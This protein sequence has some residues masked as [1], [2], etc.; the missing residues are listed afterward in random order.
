M[1]KGEYTAMKQF[2]IS[3][4]NEEEAALSFRELKKQILPGSESRMLF[5][6]FSESMDKE[7][8]DRIAGGLEKEFPGVSYVGCSTF[9]NIIRGDLCPDKY[10]AVC[11][12]FESPSAR[13]ETRQYHMGKE[14]VDSVIREVSQFANENLWV[15]AILLYTTVWET[16]MSSLCSELDKVRRDVRIAGGGAINP[17]L[18]SATSFVLSNGERA[19]DHSIVFAFIGGDDLVV[20]TRYI[21]GWKPLGKEM[22]ITKADGNILQEIE[23]ASAFDTYRRYLR[24]ENDENFLFNTLEFPY[25]IDSHGIEILRHPQQCLKDGSL[26]MASD[27]ERAGKIRLAYGDP[28]TIMESVFQN[29]Q[30]IRREQPD[31]IMIFSCAGR[32]AFWGDSDIGNETVAFQKIA[33]SSGFYTLSEF[34]RTGEHVNQHNLTLVIASMKEILPGREEEKNAEHSEDENASR[35]YSTV[36]RLANFIEEATR[37]LE[38]ANEQLFDMNLKLSNMAITDGMTHLY[39]RTEIQRRITESTEMDPSGVLSLIML[40]IDDFKKINDTFGHKE[41]DQVICALSDLMKKYVSGISG[42]STGRWG[43]EEF[44]ILLP[45]IKE[46]EAFEIAEDIRKAFEVIS[47]PQ[48][49]NRSVSLGVTQRKEHEDE[50][51]LV[52]RVDQALYEAKKE[53]KNRSVLL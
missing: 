2:Q 4:N 44:M 47:F 12:V 27:V 42:A 6:F 15:K 18:D 17:A 23:G 40:D 33:P 11:T 8:A 32:K 53:G 48:A 21:S 41:G 25:I 22:E 28:V 30:E 20:N 39:N 31:V 1:L 49:G 46:Q 52:L 19:A 24:I 37:E 38:A 50:D 16:S 26:V 7:T 14:N 5:Q 36:E 35:R 51:S 34:L 45:G 13:V 9:G 29:V 3:F 10:S 43:G